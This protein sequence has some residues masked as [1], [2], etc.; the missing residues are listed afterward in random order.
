ML[1]P[2]IHVCFTKWNGSLHWNFDVVHLGEDGHGVWLGAAD[3]TPVRR[4]NEPPI[5]SPPFA[6]LIPARGWWTATFNSGGEGSPFRSI[7]YVNICTPAIWEGS[8]VSAVDLDLDVAMR[9]DRR[10]D[11]LDEDE[12]THHLATMAYPHH[13]V[14]Q[15][16]TA[17]TSVVRM[18]KSGD[19]PFAST[20]SRWV[21]DAKALPNNLPA[22]RRVKCGPREE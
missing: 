5:L 1:P 7:A 6:L 18:M 8:T 12:F 4:G 14:D 22:I 19:E 21:E 16:R 10:V 9:P 2:M 11:L 20:G 3:D 15:A 13:V 17:A